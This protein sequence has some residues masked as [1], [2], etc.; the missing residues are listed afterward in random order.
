LKQVAVKHR[1]HLL[2]FVKYQQEY[3]S[4][5]DL[6]KLCHSVELFEVPE[7]RSKVSLIKT[8]VFSLFKRKAFV[9]C[10]YDTQPM[11]LAIRKKLSENSINIVHFDMLPLAIYLD[12]VRNSKTVLDEHNV[13]SMLLKQRADTQTR[14][15]G[16]WFFKE[17]QRLLEQFEKSACRD[18]DYIITCSQEDKETLNCFAPV[19]PVEVVPNGVDT[20]FFAPDSAVSE[21]ECN[22]IFVGGLNWFPNL[23]ALLWFDKCILPDILQ[24]FPQAHLHVIGQQSDKVSWQNKGAITCHGFV[25]N[26]KPYI[27]KATVFVVPL[28]IGGGTR[29][30]ILS[31][32]S[33]GKAVVSTTI[34]A[35]GL[36]LID[37]ENIVLADKEQ[38]FS[39]AV[40]NLFT[41]SAYRS[42]ISRNGRK[43]IF[44]HC[45]WDSIGSKLLHVY[46]KLWK[47]NPL[48]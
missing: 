36:G 11:R 33:M 5:D 25:E 48:N 44:R 8:L 17:Q 38:N 30:K 42:E 15:V 40:K 35:E 22:M 26:I 43:Y 12:E 34:G 16:K 46:D 41:D 1:I 3:N 2:S 39:I 14:L 18:V 10:K 32:M 21:E 13:E 4:I 47:T 9:V 7:N 31:A 6:E 45:Q 20:R 28:R 24:E 29:L 37:G 27:A 19:T 23:D